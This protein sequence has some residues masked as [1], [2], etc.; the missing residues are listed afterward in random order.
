MGFL[1]KLLELMAAG[2]LFG[3]V[4]ALPGA[5]R[6]RAAGWLAAAALAVVSVGRG[7]MWNWAMVH[8]MP[9][10][11]AVLVGALAWRRQRLGMA[12]VAVGY[13]AWMAQRGW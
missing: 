11:A 6:L 8:L 12:L 1:L 13:L 10:A 5:G 4:L 7:L 9:L 3:A 2:G